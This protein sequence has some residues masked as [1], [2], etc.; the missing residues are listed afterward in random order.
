MKNLKI[1][2]FGILCA[3]SVIALKPQ[4]TQAAETEEQQIIRIADG[5]TASQVKRQL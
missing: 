1:A 4:A 3:A 5:Q 2:A